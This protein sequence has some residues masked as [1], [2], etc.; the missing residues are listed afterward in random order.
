M[1]DPIISVIIQTYKRPENLGEQIEKLQNQSIQ[2]TEIIISHIENDLTDEFNFGGYQTVR[3]SHDPGFRSKFITASTVRTDCDFIAIFDDDNMPGSKALENFYESYQ[4]QPGLYGSL[5]CDLEHGYYEHSAGRNLNNDDIKQV[6]FVGQTLFFPVD[7]LMYYFDK[8][9]P[10]DIHSGEDDIWF[11]F[12]CDQHDIQR[13][14]PP[15]PTDD[16]QKWASRRMKTG[17][18]ALHNDYDDH[19]SDRLKLLDYCK[20]KGFPQNT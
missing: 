6:D 12:L 1:S 16:T 19:K 10:L 18:I 15:H 11:S 7:Y 9:C 5:G 4:E 8:F 2:P 14:V 3:F 17:N 20:D 13:F